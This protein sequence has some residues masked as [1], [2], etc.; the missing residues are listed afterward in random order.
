MA[1][2]ERARARWYKRRGVMYNPIGMRE[3][4]EIAR[5]ASLLINYTA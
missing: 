3:Y 2:E 4:S 5:L 1:I